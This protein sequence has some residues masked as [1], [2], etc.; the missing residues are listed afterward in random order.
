[1]LKDIAE[2]EGDLTKRLEIKNNDEVGILALWFNVFIGRLQDIIKDIAENAV[3]L[4]SASSDMTGLS[5]QMSSGADEIA[6][7][8]TSVSS[9]TEE[10][11]SS[12]NTVA[13]TME[14]ASVNIN[15]IATSAEQMTS[16]INEIAMNSEKAREISGRAVAKSE[17]A[18]AKV[19][20]LDQGA[21]EIGKVTEVINEISDQTGL[22]ALN[23]TIEAARAGEA[24]KGFAVVANEVKNL[25][26]QTADVGI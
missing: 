12:M 24:G 19:S 8:F 20:T 26:S 25:A 4:N 21:Q 22:L 1:M 17:K 15:M 7:T 9:S 16:T 11:S 18:S 14:Q 23:A 6:K 5:T 10:L 3:V 13:S 2:G